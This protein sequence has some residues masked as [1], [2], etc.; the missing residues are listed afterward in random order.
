MLFDIFPGITLAFLPDPVTMY[1]H[2]EN[3]YTVPVFP[4]EK[5]TDFRLGERLAWDISI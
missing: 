3:D 1:K 4:I 5:W 2:A